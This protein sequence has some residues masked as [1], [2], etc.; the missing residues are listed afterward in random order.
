MPLLGHTDWVRSVAFNVDGT[1]LA[2]A[3]DDMTILVWDM[4]NLTDVPFT[5]VG[6]TGWVTSVA[7]H[8]FDDSIASG[9]EDGTARLWYSETPGEYIIL[10]AE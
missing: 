1:T 9:S 10:G 6:H 3:S 5:L 7:F 4:E 2:S 8:P